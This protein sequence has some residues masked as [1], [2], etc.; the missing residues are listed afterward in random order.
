MLD[1]QIKKTKKSSP[2]HHPSKTPVELNDFRL[3]H[4][5]VSEQLLSSLASM[6][7]HRQ[8]TGF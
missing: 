6:R 2:K 4:F 1:A 5:I 7:L 8:P 3:L